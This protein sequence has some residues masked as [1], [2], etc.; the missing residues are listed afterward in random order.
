VKTPA[1]VVPNPA[2]AIRRR[3]NLLLKWNL[4][5]V[6]LFYKI[7][8]VNRMGNC[9]NVLLEAPSDLK[10][11]IMWHAGCSIRSLDDNNDWGT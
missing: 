1:A 3:P 5:P 7:V 2:G 9:Y 8:H 10:K 6:L 4:V 11:K